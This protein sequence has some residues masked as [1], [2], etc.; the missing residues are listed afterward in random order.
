MQQSQREE[1]TKAK[2]KDET[3]SF[4][5]IPAEYVLLPYPTTYLFAIVVACL[6]ILNFM[7]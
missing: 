5:L 2:Q 1:A 6:H 3:P 4:D 7:S